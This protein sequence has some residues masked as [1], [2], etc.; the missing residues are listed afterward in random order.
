MPISL[1]LTDLEGKLASGTASATDFI[2]RRKEDSASRIA[3]KLTENK[4]FVL[5]SLSNTDFYIQLAFIGVAV[6]L[7]WVM[8]YLIRRRLNTYFAQNPPAGIEMSL[9]TS[10]MTLLT[11]VLA[12]FYLGVAKPFA[13]DFIVGKSLTDDF[14]HLSV[15]YMLARTVLILVQS[16]PV[17]RMLAFIIMLVAVL[18]V[19]AFTQIT[20]TYLNS[21]ALDIGGVHISLLNLFNGIVIMVLVFWLSG[22]LSRALE[23]FLRRSSTLSYSARELSVKFF[24]IF[25][26]FIALLITLSALGVDLTAFAVFGGALGVGIGLGLQKITA[27]FVSGITLLLEKSIKMGDL[28]EV[29]GNIGWVRQLN[30]R[31]ALIET[32]DGKEILIP[33][34]ELIS[35]RVTNWSHSSTQIRVDIPVGVAYGTDTKLVK[36]LLLESAREHKLTLKNPE[37]Q[38]FL[39]TFAESSLNFMLMFWIGNVHD[40]RLGPQSDVMMTILE[41]FEQHGIEIPYPQRVV[42]TLKE[43]FSND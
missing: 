29:G 27:N 13:D 22:S 3:K 8:S 14:I 6:A 39:Q 16:R 25:F 20:V 5:E 35:T 36:R 15:A 19:T 2:V 12:L 23:T 26:Y 40:G 4:N 37:P 24:R 31:Y 10:S 32:A 1:E 21:I 41:K 42:R 38:C 34:E 18:K 7:A 9:L 17:A 43:A 28:I 30:I 11:P 33:N